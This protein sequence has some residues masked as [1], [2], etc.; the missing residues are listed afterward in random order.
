MFAK[1]VFLATSSAELARKAS[2]FSV[3]VKLNSNKAE[4]KSFKLF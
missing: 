1:W 3:D 4:K 2:A